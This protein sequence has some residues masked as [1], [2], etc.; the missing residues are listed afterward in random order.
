MGQHIMKKDNASIPALLLFGLASSWK[1]MLIQC[2]LMSKG[3]TV[4]TGC[5]V[6]EGTP[7][8][9][10]VSWALS[11]LTLEK[12]SLVSGKVDE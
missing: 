11:R 1:E 9:V 12:Q 4:L 10:H 8:C 3:Y 5:E 2:S 6:A 7:V